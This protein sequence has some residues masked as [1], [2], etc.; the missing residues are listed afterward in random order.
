MKRRCGAELR[1]WQIYIFRS[2]R[3]L[4]MNS[5]FG[6]LVTVFIL[7]HDFVFCFSMVW[8]SLGAHRKM[9]WSNFLKRMLFFSFRFSS[10][11]CRYYSFNCCCVFIALSI[12]L[13]LTWWAML[14]TRVTFI[15]VGVQRARCLGTAIQADIYILCVIVVSNMAIIADADESDQ[16]KSDLGYGAAIMPWCPVHFIRT[17]P[18]L[19]K[20]TNAH[21]TQVYMYML[22]FVGR[23]VQA[24]G[25]FSSFVVIPFN[26]TIAIVQV[27]TI[28]V[29]T[30]RSIH[31]E[32]E[33]KKRAFICCCHTAT[34]T[35]ITHLY[36]IWTATTHI[37]GIAAL[38][39]RRTNG[40]ISHSPSHCPALNMLQAAVI[41]A[42]SAPHSFPFITH[43]RVFAKKSDILLLFLCLLL[44]SLDSFAND[45]RGFSPSVYICC[46][47]IYMFSFHFVGSSLLCSVL[48]LFVRLCYV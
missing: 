10:I 23:M 11:W 5:I 39:T 28:A 19:W 14:M 33:S 20:V 43:G 26:S 22:R 13:Y 12:C 15:V 27:V 47:K 17:P 29:R 44:F 42:L 45:A 38:H 25:C 37:N 30:R 3:A 32:M 4:D 46:V 41:S 48:L 2:L 6:E 24:L 18:P 8:S 35:S 34:A 40:W 1:S 31:T 36:I 7:A 9:F 16:I 21:G